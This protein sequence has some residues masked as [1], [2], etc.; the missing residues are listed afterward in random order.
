MG[1][2][3]RAEEHIERM[4]LPAAHMFQRAAVDLGADHLLHLFPGIQFDIFIRGGGLKLFLPLAQRFELPLVIGEV[5]VA[6]DEIGVDVVFADA[7]ANDACAEVGDFK[8]RLQPLFAD[9]LFTASI[10]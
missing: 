5:A 7:L 9:V 3:R 1:G 2:L 6:G 10:S 4:D 8:Q